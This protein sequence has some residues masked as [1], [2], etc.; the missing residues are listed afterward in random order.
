MWSQAIFLL[1][2][3]AT[4][5]LASPFSHPFLKKTY[6]SKLKKGSFTFIMQ[7]FWTNLQVLSY[8]VGFFYVAQTWV[9]KGN[10]GQQMWMTQYEGQAKMWWQTRGT[11]WNRGLYKWAMCGR[12]IRA[13]QE[14][15]HLGRPLRG[16][17]AICLR[18]LP[19]GT[20]WRLCHFINTLYRV[21]LRV[22]R[23][24]I[25]SPNLAKLAKSGPPS[26]K[27]IFDL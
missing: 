18:S 3:T 11:Q 12:L 21:I 17:W 16:L 25:L 15:E 19:T 24:A 5:V 14:H 2:L 8:S 27:I 10:S 7:N 23:L 4:L 20:T 26:G 1:F 9:L 6:V 13:L 22:A